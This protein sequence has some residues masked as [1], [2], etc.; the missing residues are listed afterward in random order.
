[1]LTI[2]SDPQEVQETNNQWSVGIDFGTT[3]SCV[4]FKEI[5]ENQRIKF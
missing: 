3:N 5:K 2:F 4:Y 1:M